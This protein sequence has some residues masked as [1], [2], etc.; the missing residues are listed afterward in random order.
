MPLGEKMVRPLKRMQRTRHYIG[1]DVRLDNV[2][3]SASGPSNDITDEEK[4][5]TVD[6]AVAEDENTAR[7]SS[8]DSDAATSDDGASTD[9]VPDDEA[10]AGIQR[11]EAVT[12]TWSKRSLITAYIL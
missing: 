8:G 9:K 5:T 7:Q 12:L 10:Q 6:D 4:S 1:Q 11:V 3:S 2:A